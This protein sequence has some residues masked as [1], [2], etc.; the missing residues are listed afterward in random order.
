LITVEGLDS[1]DCAAYLDDQADV[2]VRSGDHCVQGWHRDREL[3]GTVRISWGLWTG[4]QDV[5]RLIDGLTQLGDD[6]ALA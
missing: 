4:E 6:F 3:R 1:H 5:Q 2:A